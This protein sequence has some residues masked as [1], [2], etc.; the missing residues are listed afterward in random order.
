MVRRRF[1]SAISNHESNHPI[2]R[3]ATRRSLLRMREEL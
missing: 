1:F 2:L 3:D